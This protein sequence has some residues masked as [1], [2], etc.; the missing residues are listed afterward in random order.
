MGRVFGR[1]AR[2]QISD[3][4]FDDPLLVREDSRRAPL[5]GDHDA[6]RLSFKVRKQVPTGASTTK[7]PTCEIALYNLAERSRRR[8]DTI[9]GTRE[10]GLILEAGYQ[11]DVGQIFR[12]EVTSVWSGR[13]GT[14]WVTRVTATTGRT[15]SMAT[16]NESLAPGASKTARMLLLLDALDVASQGGQASGLRRARARLDRGDLRGAFDELVNGATLTGPALQQ[17]Q[18]LAKDLGAEA[19]VDDDEVVM[20]AEGEV[21]SDQMVVLT[22]YTG[23]V[24]LPQRIVDEKRPAQLV[25]RALARMQWR[26][27]LGAVLELGSTAIAGLCRVRAVVHTG[28]THAEE[29]T[30]EVEADVIDRAWDPVLEREIQGELNAT[31]SGVVA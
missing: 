25:V 9:V 20:L 14:E 12:G 21:R 10:R 5:L 18:Q 15:L 13:E 26:L 29:W 1:R 3:L 4:V 16:V 27:T 28:D 24:G 11:D 19:W 23:L 8:L 31:P 17:F 30:T 22:P 6:L 7:L 2:L